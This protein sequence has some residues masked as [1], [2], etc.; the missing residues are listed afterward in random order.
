MLGLWTS[1]L[2]RIARSLLPAAAIAFAGALL[3]TGAQAQFFGGWDNGWGGWGG[4]GPG[5][6]FESISQRGFRVIGPLRRNG[7]VFVADVIDRRGRRERLI[8]AAA[9]GEILQRFILDGPRYP[10]PMPRNAYAQ[11]QQGYD[12]PTERADR[13]DLVP[14]APIPN[15]GNSSYGGRDQTAV[16]PVR[17]PQAPRVARPPRPRVV[18][19]TPED[20]NSSRREVI[21]HR[22]LLRP[23]TKEPLRIRSESATAKKSSEPPVTSASRPADTPQKPSVPAPAAPPPTTTTKLTDPLA[24]P[25]AEPRAERGPAEATKASAAVGTS[26]APRV[27]PGNVTGAPAPAVA[28]PASPPPAAPAAKPDVPVAPLD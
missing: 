28:A 23:K 16:E 6:V 5:Q 4:V 14:P 10:G 17:P 8:I 22:N 24:I 20:A 9:D 25:G 21:P 1:D 3:P 27:V 19:R 11:P 18:E 2:A 12:E 26:S 15:V 13:G 7:S